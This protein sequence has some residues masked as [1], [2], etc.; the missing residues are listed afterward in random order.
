MVHKKQQLMILLC[1]FAFAIQPLIAE[2]KAEAGLGENVLEQ[3]SKAFTKIAK[4]AIPATVFI[5]ATQ[6]PSEQEASES[7]FNFFN[8]D[9]FQKFFRGGPLN[10]SQ[11]S[12]PQIAGGSGFFVSSDG[13]IV[14]NYHVIKEAK[15][16]TVVLNDG[17]EFS[18]TV[19]GS[20]PRTDL[21]V[22]KVEGTNFSPLQ[23]GDSDHL[24]IGEWVI[25]IGNPFALESSLTVGVV[26]AKGRQDLGITAF[27]DFI[28]TDAAIN[29]GNSGGPLLDIHNHVIGVNT[30]IMTQTGGYMGIGLAIPSKMAKHVIDQIIAHGDVKRAYLGVLLQ[31]LDKELADAMGLDKQEGVMISDVI[32]ESPAEKAGLKQ[33]DIISSYDNK[34]VKNMAAFRNDIAMM[35]PGTEIKL[36]VLRNGKTLS[37]TASMSSQIDGGT[38]SAEIIQ[39]LGLEIENL[40]PEMAS[41]L[42]YPADLRG[43]VI[44]KVKPGSPAAKV[45][46]RPPFLIVGVVIDWNHQKRISNAT[47]FKEA[48]K[49]IGDK[50]HVILI[51]HHQNYQRFYT[52]K[53]G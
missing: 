21:A 4:T 52:L 38:V 24:D 8:D 40:T 10:R 33:G 42:G 49:A 7:P 43:V 1:S 14:T 6:P 46:L 48:L 32:K 15:Q 11:P 9:L 44:A 47:D 28:Q 2:Q 3:S 20:D 18:A 27:E 5:K 16:I 22:L 12:Q 25:A 31:P 19:T 41:R 36:R 30:A 23:F 39:K 50:K 45:N 17:R 26:S 29:P 51:V 53:L 13:F 34:P 35:S 37:I